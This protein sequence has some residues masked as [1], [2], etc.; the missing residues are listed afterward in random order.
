M[1]LG[2]TLAKLLAIQS[3]EKVLVLTDFKKEKVGRKIFEE[4]KGRA[5]V[6]FFIMK[7]RS[8]DGW[9]TTKRARELVLE[10]T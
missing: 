3:E 1:S 4:L 2:E 7:T 5:N 9:E 10:Q 6:K 8:R